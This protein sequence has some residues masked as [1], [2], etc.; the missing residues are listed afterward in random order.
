MSELKVGLIFKPMEG[1]GGGFR[2][3]WVSG[4]GNGVEFGLDSGAGLGNGYLTLWI[5]KKGEKDRRYY[6]ASVKEMLESLVD[7]AMEKTHV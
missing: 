2:Q 7:Q 6:T 4:K 5:K 1:F 3:E